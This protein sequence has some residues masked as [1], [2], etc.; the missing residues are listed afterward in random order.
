MLNASSLVPFP[1]LDAQAINPAKLTGIM[2]HQG[3]IQRHCLTRE[4]EVV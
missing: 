3:H 2:R 4:L 1:I